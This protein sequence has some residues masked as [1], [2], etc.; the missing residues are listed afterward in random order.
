M[1]VED[2]LRDAFRPIDGFE[3]SPDLFQRLDRSLEE[4][5]AMRRRRATVT[6]WAIVGAALLSAW[7]GLSAEEGMGG[8]LFIEGWRLTLAAVTVSGVLIVYL[9][10]LI[11]RFGQGLIDEVFRLSPETGDRFLAVLDLTFYV[12]FAGLAL[13]DADLWG[14]GERLLLW[15]A[16]EDIAFRIGFLLFAMGALHVINIALLPVVGVVFSS[17]V[18]LERRRKA[19]GDAPRESYRARV[20]DRNARSLALGLAVTAVALVVTLLA[21]PLGALLSDMLP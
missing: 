6:A 5:R 21:G 11:R 10:P 9:G 20:A 1:S 3:P 8:R 12:V 7:V 13:V 2:R 18:R 14:L 16:L 17:I 15:P 19:G 4:D